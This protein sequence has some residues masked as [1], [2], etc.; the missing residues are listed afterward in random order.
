MVAPP[1]L[2][3][4]LALLLLLLLLLALLLLPLLLPLLALPL[5][6]L[7]WVLLLP[8]VLQRR[9]RTLR[10]KRGWKDGSITPLISSAR[11]YVMSHFAIARQHGAAQWR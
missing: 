8:L 11:R 4:L 9:R 2:L 1:L 7:V 10:F 5:L 3:L 6:L